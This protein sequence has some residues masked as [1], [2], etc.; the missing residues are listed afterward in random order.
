MKLRNYPTI[1]LF[2]LLFLTPL[3]TPIP[4]EAEQA[5][6]LPVVK[7]TLTPGEHLID[8]LRTTY[9]VPDNL[10]FNEYLN[11]IKELNPELKN[12]NSLPDHQTIL[13]PLTPP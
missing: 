6:D 11:L 5:V 13:I 3:F 2:Y 9:K 4:A 12:L 7:H 10:I 1:V 8:V